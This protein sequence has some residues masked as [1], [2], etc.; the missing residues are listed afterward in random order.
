MFLYL[1][2]KYTSILCQCVKPSFRCV[3]GPV[4]AITYLAG[5]GK[6]TPSRIS[7]CTTLHINTVVKECNFPPLFNNGHIR[8]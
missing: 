8:C 6:R 7:T 1:N 2:I 3:D 5:C 4:V